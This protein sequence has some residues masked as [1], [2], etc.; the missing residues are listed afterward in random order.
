MKRLI[1][2]TTLAVSLGLSTFAQAGCTLYE[3]R[4]FQ[5]AAWHLDNLETMIMVDG[6]DIGCTTNGHGSGCPSYIYEGSWND[7][8]SSFDV[9]PGCTLTLWEDINEGG[10]HFRS[11][12]GYSY[13]GGDWNDE[14]SEAECI[15]T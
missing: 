10:Y 13:V 8:V 2:G 1:F 3:H 12:G 4:D 6:E 5:G 7:A 11:D 9:D 14:A 15:C